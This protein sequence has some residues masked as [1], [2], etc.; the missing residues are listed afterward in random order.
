MTDKDRLGSFQPN[1]KDLRVRC[2]PV[3]RTSPI[4]N[5]L[6]FGDG[7]VTHLDTASSERDT[8]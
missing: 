6:L 3:M 2:V 4:D 5:L 1:Q 8:I 7:L